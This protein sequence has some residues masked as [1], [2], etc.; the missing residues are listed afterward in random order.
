LV[1]EQTRDHL[2]L[3]LAVDQRELSRIERLLETLGFRHDRA[4]EPGL[5]ARLVLRDDRG[6]EIDLHPLVF[7]EYGNGWQQLSG[8]GR[9]WGCY[10]AEHLQATGTIGDCRARCLSAELHV[11]FRMGYELSERDEHDLRLLARTFDLPP[12]ATA[13]EV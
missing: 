11:R 3:D 5:P 2:D 7:D 13:L 12:T 1:G 6:R 4:V 8:S 9:A 10:P